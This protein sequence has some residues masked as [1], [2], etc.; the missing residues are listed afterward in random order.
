MIKLNVERERECVGANRSE[1]R[2]DYG[3]PQSSVCVNM[4]RKLVGIDRSLGINYKK[5]P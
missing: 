2:G 5:L 1:N 4:H 3:P